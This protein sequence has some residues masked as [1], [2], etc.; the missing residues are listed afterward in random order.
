[1][2]SSHASSPAPKTRHD[3]VHR[4]GPLFALI[5]TFL[6]LFV[7]R[8]LVSEVVN[9]GGVGDGI[10][11]NFNGG[12]AQLPPL[13]KLVIV[14]VGGG[15]GLDVINEV[16]VAVQNAMVAEVVAVK[17]L[18]HRARHVSGPPST[19]SLSPKAHDCG[20][21]VAV[22]KVTPAGGVEQVDVIVVSAAA[23]DGVI[24]YVEQAVGTCVFQQPPVT[25]V[26]PPVTNCSG[27]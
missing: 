10:D 2:Q 26:S 23:S 18:G 11:S 4:A 13:T 21:S 1:M 3:R 25:I 14:V 20:A 9:G 16:G 24:S 15:D 27:T 19:A 7:L 6:V 8:E 5:R 22:E 17:P 12:G